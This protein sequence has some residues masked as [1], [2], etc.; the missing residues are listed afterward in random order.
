M[1]TERGYS[2][3][4]AR[5]RLYS[6][7]SYKLL[8]DFTYSDGDCFQFHNKNVLAFEP[9]GTGL[10]LLCGHMYSNRIAGKLMALKLSLPSLKIIEQRFYPNNDDHLYWLASGIVT[11]ARG[12]IAWQGNYGNT[13]LLLTDI[14]H[15]QPLLILSNLTSKDLAGNLSFIYANIEGSQIKLVYSGDFK[16]V[17]DPPSRQKNQA[18]FGFN[19]TLI[20]DL[21]SGALLKKHD[22]VKQRNDVS[23]ST[24][25]SIHG[26]MLKV[27]SNWQPDSKTGSI[28][29]FDERTGK[30]LQHIDTQAQRL[31]NLS[32][33]N[34]WLFSYAFESGEIRVYRVR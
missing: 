10:W 11:T 28:E 9:E 29:V 21:F 25:L 13:S 24:R 16:D 17:L 26:L 22:S 12:V 15:N 3:Q 32:K 8:G 34:R 1:I 20:Y 4:R 33:D 31:L 6:V 14:S 5:V 30:S 23:V 7:P 19:R 2:R 18:D 27:E